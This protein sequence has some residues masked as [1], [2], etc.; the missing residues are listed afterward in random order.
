MGR[1][2]KFLKTLFIAFITTTAAISL[3][4]ADLNVAT[5]D[6]Q[7]A[8]LSTNFAKKEIEELENSDE[9]KEVIEELQAKANEAREI[10][11]KTQKDGPTMSDDEKQD[12]AQKFQFSSTRYK[13]SKR[14]N[15]SF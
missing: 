1:I 10:Q 7:A 9:W 3:Q 12:A 2:M 13:L 15:N 6:P 4:A 5:I 14:K 11:E 8:L